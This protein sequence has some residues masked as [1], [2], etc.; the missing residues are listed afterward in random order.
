MKVF[1]SIY[2][3]TRQ[4]YLRHGKW[5]NYLLHF[6]IWQDASFSI[7]ILRGG[8]ASLKNFIIY[9]LERTLSKNHWL[10]LVHWHSRI[11]QE[12]SCLLCQADDES[13]EHIFFQCSHFHDSRL[14]I[15]KETIK[16]SFDA[17]SK[18]DTKAMHYRASKPNLATVTEQITKSSLPLV[19]F[20]RKITKCFLQ[21]RFPVYSGSG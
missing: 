3:K 19:T 9:I 15:K 4:V 16:I 20:C 10:N 2:Q 11:Y 7:L 14:A 13:I 18:N 1:Q 12:K 6:S 17:I 21:T 8:K 5:H